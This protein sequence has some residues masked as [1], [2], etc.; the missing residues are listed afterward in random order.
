MNV[1]DSAGEGPNRTSPPAVVDR[2]SNTSSTAQ[3]SYI[4]PATPASQMS[5]QSNTRANTHLQQQL[6]ISSHLGNS[7]MTMGNSGTLGLNT[8]SGTTGGM[9][10]LRS[11]NTV[12]ST[13]SMHE[14][15]RNSDSMRTPT[16]KA[17]SP[18]PT[19]NTA[20]PDHLAK[21]R[22]ATTSDADSIINYKKRNLDHRLARLK[23]VKEK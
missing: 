4:G 8:A 3:M 22:S 5:Q 12:V 19:T 10:I 7:P 6:A 21:K 14:T 11:Q 16:T 2:R 20:S 9:G 17:T 18:T 15:M 13:S 23:V 1:G